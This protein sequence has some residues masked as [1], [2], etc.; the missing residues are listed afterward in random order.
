MLPVP[1]E[2]R[3]GRTFQE[4]VV[5][6][7]VRLG[8][9]G[10]RSLEETAGPAFLGALEQA[11]PALS[12]ERGICTMLEGVFGGDYCFGEDAPEE[13]RWRV[14][15][16]SGC[17]EGQ[18]LRTLWASLQQE[19]Q[20]AAV[21]LMREGQ[22]T[23]SQE[24][25]SV[26]GSSTDGSTRGRITE[27]RDLTRGALIKKGLQTHPQQTRTN[28]PV[29]AW[30]QRDK[31]SS[32]W[33]QA[34]PGPDS[35]LTSAEFA[36]ASAAALC[37][38]SPACKEKLGEKVTGRSV[39]DL[40]GDTVQ[41]ARLPG[42]HWRR[43]HDRIKIRFYQ[44]CQWAG[45]PC[46]MEVFN[47]FA[48]S[49]PQEGLN[50]MERGRKVQSIVPD[51]RITL[52]VEGNPVP[53]LHELKCISSSVTRYLP[54]WQG[55]EAV[56]AVDKRAGQLHQ[57]YVNKARNTDRKYCGTPEGITGPVENKL[58]SMGAIKG[59]VLGCFG[60]ASQA[61]HDLIYHLAVSRVRVAGPQ[62]GRRGQFREEQA[63]VALQTAFLRRTI[64]L[65]GVKAQSFSLLGRLEGL[66][67]GGSAAARRRTYALNL[68]RQWGN[69]R[70]AHALSVRQ[71][72]NILRSGQFMQL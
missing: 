12:G 18:E 6:H 42:D 22:D 8:G 40:Y 38:P 20:Q 16:Q 50:R 26:G 35:S 71:G 66:G 31:L 3:G 14:M 48:G 70:R 36:E 41:S 45:V 28:R 72:R 47:L 39:V 53:S 55:Q 21:W 37:L 44:L 23:L 5:R 24:L 56:K 49:I 32:A 63:E 33:L 62:R 61:T 7:P 43:R 69:L 13:S 65:C 2:G 11:I 54:Q 67:S 60:E 17:Q 27:E 4:W 68:E 19:E 30:L 52:E 64:S 29:W 46:E 57:S 34:L 59:V 58:A 25:E 15:L 10:L 51:L 1:V 9:F